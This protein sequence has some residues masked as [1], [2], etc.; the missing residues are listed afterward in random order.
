MLL[1]QWMS[2][3]RKNNSGGGDEGQ[4]AQKSTQLSFFVIWSAKRDRVAQLFI[5]TLEADA[6]PFFFFPPD[7]LPIW[8]IDARE[9]HDCTK[10][11]E[12][13]FKNLWTFNELFLLFELY[14]LLLGPHV[15][16]VAC[17]GPANLAR[18]QQC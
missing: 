18:T 2:Q 17:A 5:G 15:R 7:S 14:W 4:K 9:K 13:L 6:S 16:T 10:M 8:R 12:K 11:K 1:E 3:W